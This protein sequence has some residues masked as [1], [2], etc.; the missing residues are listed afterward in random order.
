MSNTVS[1][2]MP[3]LLRRTVAAI[4][5][6]ADIGDIHSML[7]IEEG[8]TDYQAWLTYKRAVILANNLISSEGK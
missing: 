6:S 1:N 2:P 8:L 5:M 4:C 7:T 3:D